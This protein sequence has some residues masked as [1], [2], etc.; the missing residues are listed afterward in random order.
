MSEE[1]KPCIVSCC[2]NVAKKRDKYC[3]MHRARLQRT[4]RLDLK[5]L[6]EKLIDNIKIAHS[7]CWEWQAYKSK[8]GYGRVRVKGLKGA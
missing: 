2:G 1:L 6:G 5:S 4:G 8:E 7:G 3:S